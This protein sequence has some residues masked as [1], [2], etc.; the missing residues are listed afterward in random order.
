MATIERGQYRAIPSVL[1][2]GKDFRALSANARWVFVALKL[3]LGP[4]GIEVHYRRALAEQLA[5]Q[6][7]LSTNAV[8][9]AL[10]DLEAA[11]W[12]E[13]DEN[14]VW[15]VRQL[16]FEPNMKP[17]D[18][19]HRTSIQRHAL[20]LPR[21]PIVARFIATYPAWFPEGEFTPPQGLTRPSEGPTKALVTTEDREPRTEDREPSVAA[22]APL[23]PRSRAQALPTDWQP[24]DDH[25]KL[26]STLMN[27]RLSVE[28]QKFRDHFTANGKPMK[29][30]DAAFRNWLRRAQDFA[31]T[32]PAPTTE[33][34]AVR[35]ELPRSTAPRQGPDPLDLTKRKAQEDQDRVNGW[36]KANP[37]RA[38]AM[39]AEIAG[40]LADDP[41]WR[42]APQGMVGGEIRRRFSE[43]VLPLLTP[44]AVA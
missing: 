33:A 40:E 31:P 35:E 30:W 25:R 26:A 28:V 23:N 37:E 9:C 22:P 24:N 15:V 2:D 27:V 20:G 5:E 41:R 17:A 34:A 4:A 13:R 19:K 21:L 6:T 1:L 7:G 3:N 12:I 11:E 29:D 43:R 38:E 16:E 39:L 36:A 8:T 32:K 10:N 42:G 44:K 18:S 14:I